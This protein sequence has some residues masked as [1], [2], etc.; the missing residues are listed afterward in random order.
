M[1]RMLL[2]LARQARRILLTALMGGLLG[3]TL[4]RFSPGFGMDEREMDSRLSRE[5]QDAARAEHASD[6]NIGAFYLR[7]LTGALHGDFGFSMTLNRPISALLRE[8]LPVTLS[9]LAWGAGLGLFAG[10]SLA[11]LTV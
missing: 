8:R 11:L 5:S 3:A 6:R 1:K 10:I 7:Y 4:V 9:S 2:A